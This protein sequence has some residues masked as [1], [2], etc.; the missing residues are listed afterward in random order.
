MFIDVRACTL[1]PEN[2]DC[3]PI[4]LD[5]GP[6]Y[7]HCRYLI[8]IVIDC[9][10]IEFRNFFKFFFSITRGQ[11]N[12]AVMN[13]TY[14]IIYADSLVRDVGQK[15][16]NY[17]FFFID[18]WSRKICYSIDTKQPLLTFVKHLHSVY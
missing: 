6:A 15:K 12:G 9:A 10:V 13:T 5:N 17:R 1:D 11:I 3:E 18:V 8:K 4:L 16:P 2:I 7:T 14:S